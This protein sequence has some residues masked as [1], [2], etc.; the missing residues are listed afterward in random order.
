MAGSKGSK[1]LKTQTEYQLEPGVHFPEIP[2][3][4]GANNQGEFSRQRALEKQRKE[5]LVRGRNV[6]RGNGVWLTA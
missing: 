5:M 6:R 4:S 1:G 2:E 3:M